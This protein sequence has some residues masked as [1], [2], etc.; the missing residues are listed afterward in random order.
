MI[1]RAFKHVFFLKNIKWLQLID[2]LDVIVTIG[3]LYLF[4]GFSETGWILWDIPME[5]FVTG[6][7]LGNQ[8]S[9][10][11]MKNFER[12]WNATQRGT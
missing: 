2:F 5:S 9:F 7:D 6:I 11:F 4:R 12:V 10:V 8:L 1:V 3:G